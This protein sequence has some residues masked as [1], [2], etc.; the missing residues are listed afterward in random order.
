MKIISHRGNLE[1]RNPELENHPEYIERCIKK[2]FCAEIDVWCIDGR[3]M[4]GH[5]S[6]Q[7]VVEESWMNSFFHRLWVHA[8]NLEAV[9]L[10]SKNSWLNWFWH[11]EDLMTMTSK[12]DIWT[13]PG[14]Y[15]KNGIVVENEFK[16]L[17]A[18]IKGVCTDFPILYMNHEKS[19]SAI[20]Q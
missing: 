10:L 9:E 20:H 13:Y 18:F 16:E 14:I 1:G 12:G 11:E 17:P 6:G 5:D 3:I 2:G 7:Y 15:V 19:R 4:L 8:K